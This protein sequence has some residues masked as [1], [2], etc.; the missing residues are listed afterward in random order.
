MTAKIQFY[1]LAFALKMARSIHNMIALCIIYTEHIRGEF[2]VFSFK[3]ILSCH[4]V[5]NKA[6]PCLWIHST[7]LPTLMGKFLSL[8]NKSIENEQFLFF[9]FF[10]KFL[11]LSV[12]HQTDKTNA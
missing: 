4:V 1:F 6:C 12:L 11:Y 8:F 9:I 10:E 3:R 2:Q 5:L 7:P